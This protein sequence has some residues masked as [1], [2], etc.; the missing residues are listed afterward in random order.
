MV[1]KLE[2]SYPAYHN[3]VISRFVFT[4]NITLNRGYIPGENGKTIVT[5]TPFNTRKF[6][7]PA[8]GHGLTYDLLILS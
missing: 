4:L 2:I 6:I 8:L 5:W 3:R 7:F 1:V